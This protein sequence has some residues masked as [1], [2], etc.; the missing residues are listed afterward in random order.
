M[1]Q[2]IK[3]LPAVQETW[4]QYLGW[5]DSPGEGNGCHSS[6]VAWRTPWTVQSVGL[7]RVRQ[8][9]ATFTLTHYLLLWEGGQSPDLLIFPS[10]PFS[11]RSHEERDTGPKHVYHCILRAMKYNHHWKHCV[12]CKPKD[13]DDGGG[14]CV[15]ARTAIWNPLW[16]LV[17]QSSG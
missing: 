8:D 13:D 1:T 9:W 14:V 2:L 15:C 11:R 16:E 7:Q 3:N 6:I 5:E 17:W 12:N 10:L 4:V